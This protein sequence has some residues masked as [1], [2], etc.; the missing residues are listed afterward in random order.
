MPHNASPVR[1]ATLAALLV[2]SYTPPA[3]AYIDP[4]AAGAA[5]Q[6]LY[7]IMASALMTVAILPQKVAAGFAWVKRKLTGKGPDEP[8]SPGT[9]T[10][11]GE[12]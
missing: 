4:T 9:G 3:F 12:S 7:I 11:T 8:P 10:G 5:L 1:I 2:V 6:S